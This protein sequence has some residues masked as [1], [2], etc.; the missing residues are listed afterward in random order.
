MHYMDRMKIVEAAKE[1]S[2]DGPDCLLVELG[3]GL[4]KIDDGTTVAEL[5]HNLVPLLPLKH[6]I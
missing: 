6:F 5:G 4:D 3:A 2:E 1:L